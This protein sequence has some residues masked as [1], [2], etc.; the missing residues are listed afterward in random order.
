MKD[1]QRCIQCSRELGVGYEVSLGGCAHGSFCAIL[2]ALREEGIEFITPEQEDEVLKAILAFTG[3][4][5]NSNEGTCGAVVGSAAAISLIVGCTRA[6]QENDG[7]KNSR[8]VA[9]AVNTA[10][11]EPFV[12]KYGSIICRDLLYNTRGLSFCSQYPGRNK[13]FF[14]STL[15]IDC[16]H[17]ET[18]VISNAANWA[19][20]FIRD[21]LD[22]KIDLNAVWEKYAP[23]AGNE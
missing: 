5:G 21:Y 1:F 15:K 20:D 19:L 14:A 7:G 12:A 10:V 4:Y 6:Q 13:E 23:D 16:R 18:C 3:G 22:G 17:A 9:H 8:L 11:V 2:D